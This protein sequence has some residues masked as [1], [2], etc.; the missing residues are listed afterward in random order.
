MED[1]GLPDFAQK[2]VLFY[3]K[4]AFSTFANG[5][6]LSEIVFH[7]RRGRVFISGRLPHSSDQDW[8]GNC[9]AELEWDAVFHFVEFADLDD[10]QK[11][12]S[13]YRSGSQGLFGRR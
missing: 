13:G 9:K 5:I 4:D 8:Q 12:A 2:V 7:H 6:V 1:S 3:L 10:Y 11:R